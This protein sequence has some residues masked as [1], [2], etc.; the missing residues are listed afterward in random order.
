MSNINSNKKIVKKNAKEKNNR[1]MYSIVEIVLLL[2]VILLILFLIAL[3]LMHNEYVT[4]EREYDFN[5]YNISNDENSVTITLYHESGDRIKTEEIYYFENGNIIKNVIKYY[6]KRVNIAKD[7]YNNGIKMIRENLNS[8]LVEQPYKL[9]KKENAVIYIYDNPEVTFS[10]ADGTK[11]VELEN[12]YISYTTNEQ[13]INYFL[14]N[15]NKMYE[16]Y[17]TKVM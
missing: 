7:E 8:G 4:Y 9:T 15:I 1:N 14:D 6:Y 2:I 11:D 3:E 13:I 16:G 10:K 17:Y 5:A 12:K